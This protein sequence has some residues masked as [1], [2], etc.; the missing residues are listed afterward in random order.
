MRTAESFFQSR[1]KKTQLCRVSPSAKFSEPIYQSSLFSLTSCIY[2]SALFLLLDFYRAFRYAGRKH[3]NTN[4]RAIISGTEV[5]FSA[6]FRAGYRRFRYLSIFIKG[7]HTT[8]SFTFH[9]AKLDANADWIPTN[10]RFD[11]S[12][13][14]I[15][16]KRREKEYGFYSISGKFLGFTQKRVINVWYAFIITLLNKYRY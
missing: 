4:T 3:G 5:D 2:N 16:P 1:F 7:P 15:L 12:A 8:L 14:P 9:R 10:P 13:V 11:E 6:A